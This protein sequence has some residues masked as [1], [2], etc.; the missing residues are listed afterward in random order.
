MRKSESSGSL[1]STA[2]ANRYD[3][4]EWAGALGDLG[5]LVPFV[6]AYVSV[7][8]LEPFGVL[9]GFGVSMVCCGW[10]YKTPFPV[11]PMKAIGAV[12]TSQTAQAS[13]ITP[14]AVYGAGLA[15]GL[16][17]LFLG[18]TGI[19]HRLARWVSQ[20]VAQGVVLGLALAFMLQGA[21]LMAEQWLLAGAGLFVVLALAGSRR[22]P[23]IFALL[24]LG[25]GWTAL[26]QPELLMKLGTFELQMQWPVWT[27][28]RINGPDLLV[29]TMLL[30]LPQVPLTLG[31]AIIGVRAEN[32]RLFPDRPVTDRKVA[33]ST[34]FL[35][36]FGS[37]VGGVPM[38]HGAG[39]MAGHVAF[40]ARTGG[41]LVILGGLL[42]LLALFFSGSVLT[43]FEA[44]PRAVL[45]TILFVA[46]VQLA[47]VQIS[48]R[49]DRRALGVMLI[50]A[51]LAAWN[52][53][54][55][56]GVGLTLQHIVLRRDG[57]D[58]A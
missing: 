39:G 9:F 33:L 44:I 35:N 26:R 22:V 14:G 29:G 28:P 10:F 4:R 30:A 54:L 5:T 24:I 38:C 32:N 20:P 12:A 55:G 48:P 23:A 43:L 57:F 53:A 34:G 18:A 58:E 49:R 25:V 6:M 7:L 37:A 27:W 19:A 17:W 41:S 51:A 1:T 16:I 42:L 56:L 31:N 52:A 15:T 8:K 50:T 45:G 3:R 36:L 2:P 40:G 11:Q 13:A 21:K 47:K 46:G